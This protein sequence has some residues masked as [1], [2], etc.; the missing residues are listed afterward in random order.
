MVG[1]ARMSTE[2]E[3]WLQANYPELYTEWR[4]AY[5]R[6]CHKDFPPGSQCRICLIRPHSGLHYSIYTC[7]ADK[8]FLKRTFHE[9]QVYKICRLQC[10]P[11]FR[12]WCQYCRLQFSLNTGINLKMIRMGER[13]KKP[14]PKTPRAPRKMRKMDTGGTPGDVVK[15]E[16]PTWQPPR[17]SDSSLNSTGSVGFNPGSP[18]NYEPHSFQ[19]YYAESQKHSYPQHPVSPDN[20]PDQII[21]PLAQYHPHLLYNYWHHCHLSALGSWNYGV[22]QSPVS[23]PSLG[24][25]VSRVSS[26]IQDLPLDLSSSSSSS[27]SSSRPSS[28]G[29]L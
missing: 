23:S 7:E 6:P 14:G 13:L 28:A 17:D 22:M 20:K 10:P 8:Q 27:S 24:W 3:T 11:R 21:H 26:P 2:A 4:S 16:P 19:P 1:P 18:I 5:L 29:G 12:G 9:R 15:I 25:G